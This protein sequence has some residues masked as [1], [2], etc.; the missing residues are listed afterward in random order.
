MSTFLILVALVGGDFCIAPPID[1]RFNTTMVVDER[2][3]TLP[4]CVVC[5]CKYAGECGS[6]SCSACQVGCFEAY[7]SGGIIHVNADGRPSGLP[8]VWDT[9]RQT[10]DNPYFFK[11]VGG[12][13][14]CAN[15]P[16]GECPLPTASTTTTATDTCETKVKHGKRAGKVKRGGLFKGL[17]KGKKCKGC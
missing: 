9:A 17:F 7:P 11:T 3:A 15:C 14:A 12:N 2:P 6:P 1:P 8:V 5:Q 10:A 13:R 16:N 4:P